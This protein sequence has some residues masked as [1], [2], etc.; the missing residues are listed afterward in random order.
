MTK[1]E[2]LPSILAIFPIVIAISVLPAMAQFETPEAARPHIDELSNEVYRPGNAK[3]ANEDLAAFCKKIQENLR[4]VDRPQWE[5]VV[6][7]CFEAKRRMEEYNP[8]RH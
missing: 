7:K 8:G 4:G 3:K 1:R 5:S 2:L 6:A